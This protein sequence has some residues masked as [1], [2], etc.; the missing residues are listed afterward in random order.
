MN[1]ADNR[2]SEQ[3]AARVVEV[4]VRIALLGLL[5]YLCFKVV[6]PFMTLMLWGIIL[7]VMLYPMH[8]KLAARLGG[9]QGR[10]ATVISLIGCAV[11]IVPMVLL[12]SS[13]VDHAQEIQTKL[14]NNELK[15]EPPSA[16]VAE[17]PIVGE[18]VYGLWS[19]ASENSSQFVED[20]KE[21]IQ[22]LSKKGLT[23][24]KGAFSTV[25][26]FIAA[27]IVAGIMMAWGE[28]GTNAMRRVFSRIAGTDNGP[29]LQDLSVGTVRSVASGVLGVA[30]IQAFLFG[31]GFILA[32]IPAAGALAL[33]VLML[34]ILQLPAL[35]LSITVISYLWSG[36]ASTV[37][38]VGFTIYF[39]VAGFSDG[40]LKP[41]LLGRGVDAPMPVILI[42]A[43]G[44]MAVSGFIGLFLGA[45][46]LALGYKIFMGWVDHD[47]SPEV[48]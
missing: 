25:G 24:A 37:F 11:L 32:G 40:V 16:K 1:S 42:G 34:G 5:A 6:S 28:S 18:K 3:A 26:L 12:A 31:I 2:E 30:F 20:Y 7:A 43:L 22:D 17:W 13:V 36:D 27:L 4:A 9:K 21:Q 39:I 45:T 14:N 38:N 41:I 8:Q 35:I 44:G 23:A 47:W 46:L 10:A 15:L 19:E 33:I 48:D 29:D